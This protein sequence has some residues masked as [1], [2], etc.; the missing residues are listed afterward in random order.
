MKHHSRIWRIFPAI[1]TMILLILDTDTARSGMSEGIE[2]CIKVIIP[3]LFPFF[4]VTTYLNYSL[5]GSQIPLFKFLTKSLHIPAGSES[6]LLLGLVG[7]YPVGAKLITDTYNS[8]HINKRTAHILL[9]YCNNAGPAFIFGI[10]T[11][12]FS[13]FKYSFMLWIIH[14]LSALLTGFLLPKPN[15]DFE[16]QYSFSSKSPAEIL[17]NS[18]QI[19][20]SVCGWIILFKVMLSYLTEWLVPLIGSYGIVLL[21]GI[22]E[23]SNGCTQLIQIPNE[24]LRFILSAS[25]LSLGGLC[26]LLQTISATKRLGLGLYIPG[27]LMQTCIS[28]SLSC[29]YIYL[30]GSHIPVTILLYGVLPIFL[31]PIIQSYIKKHVEIRT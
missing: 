14:I 29:I 21:Y 24:S 19:C 27:K 12:L 7:G 16:Y 8:G 3:S 23:L 15:S 30:S 20:V 11:I 31:I 10:T 9:G 22:T 4:F 18:I 25:F 6:L 5:L 13:S 17:N 26:V 1:V 28:I 2:V